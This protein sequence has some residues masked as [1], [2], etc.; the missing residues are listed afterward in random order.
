MPLPVRRW[1]ATRDGRRSRP[2]KFKV[3]DLAAC[4]TSR[5]EPF[6]RSARDSA[7]VPSGMKEV[8]ANSEADLVAS[9]FETAGRFLATI[10]AT[11]EPAAMI[12]K[13]GKRPPNAEKDW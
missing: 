2:C 3:V 11:A 4:G 1:E 12:G 9:D 5:D 13:L 6:R 7:A 10:P 8:E